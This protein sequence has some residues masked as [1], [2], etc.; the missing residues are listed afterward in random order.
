MLCSVYEPKLV[1]LL[2]G[3]HDNTLVNLS[4]DRT[5]MYVRER[6]GSGALY[7]VGACRL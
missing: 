7:S 1:S 4:Y 2:A 5:V 6:D 3:I